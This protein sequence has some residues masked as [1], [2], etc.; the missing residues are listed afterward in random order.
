MLFSVGGFAE[1]FG[2]LVLISFSKKS[3]N[4]F[5]QV[6]HCLFTFKTETID[7]HV[8]NDVHFSV[9]FVV[10]DLASD[11]LKQQN[12]HI[13]HISIVCSSASLTVNDSI[14]H[15][16][17]KLNNFTIRNIRVHH[18]VERTWIDVPHP[19]YKHSTLS[20]PAE[21]FCILFSNKF[22]LFKS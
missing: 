21:H 3:N 4:S 18:T 6:L 22:N 20:V 17:N 2:V 14:S 7:L 16:P 9:V 15:I 19:F 13:R 8:Q 5:H 10:E 11:W 1:C 12:K